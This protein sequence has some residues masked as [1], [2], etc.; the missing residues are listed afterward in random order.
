M[1]SN[2]LSLRFSLDFRDKISCPY[3]PLV[4]LEFCIF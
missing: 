4:K 2:T 3:T 1:F